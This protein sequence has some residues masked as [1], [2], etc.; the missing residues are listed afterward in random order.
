VFEGTRL[1]GANQLIRLSVEPLPRQPRRAVLHLPQVE[2][3]P[4]SST[5]LHHTRR[6]FPTEAEAVAE[7]LQSV[8]AQGCA[9]RAELLAARLVV[10][11][12][13]GGDLQQIN[14]MRRL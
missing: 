1:S 7:L 4:K 11:R 14:R 5:R 10:I 3:A 8:L 13:L 12:R 9:L 2:T 6:C